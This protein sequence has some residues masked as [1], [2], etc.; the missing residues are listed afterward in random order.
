MLNAAS[1]ASQVRMPASA[2]PLTC[3]LTFLR[4]GALL[5]STTCWRGKGTA[6]RG[7]FMAT[8]R[9]A[10]RARLTDLRPALIKF[11]TCVS[12]V[13]LASRSSGLGSFHAAQIRI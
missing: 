5:V 7:P 10:R 12:C 2:G 13:T 1:S 11:F 6:G 9:Q 8:E 4:H 3:R